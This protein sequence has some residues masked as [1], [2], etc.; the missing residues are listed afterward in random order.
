MKFSVRSD[1]FSSPV[2]SGFF[3]AP[4]TPAAQPVGG[5]ILD[6]VEVKSPFSLISAVYSTLH[7]R[8]FFRESN[9]SPEKELCQGSDPNPPADSQ[10]FS[11]PSREWD[12][13]PIEK[14]SSIE[15]APGVSER[16]QDGEK[17]ELLEKSLT[18][19]RQVS[20]GYEEQLSAVKSELQQAK[21]DLGQSRAEAKEEIA[22]MVL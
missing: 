2:G 9:K 7:L 10:V 11:I 14:V 3:A 22:N 4:S 20:A 6:S 21:I 15:I 16:K 18:E 12:F 17:I 19:L 8:P 5:L 13:H 1:L